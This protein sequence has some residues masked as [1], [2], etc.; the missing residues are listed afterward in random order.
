M[1]DPPAG[2]EVAM[3]SFEAVSKR[4]GSLV[5]IDQVS[6]TL[7]PGHI[8]SIIGPNGAGKSTLINLAA[9]S[10]AVSAGRIM[11]DG[12][13]LTRLKKH[14]ICAAGLSRTYQNIRLFD[15]ISAVENL[16][17][18]LFREDI[19][20]L[21]A[22]VFRPQRA[23]AIRALRRER[24]MAV[25]GEF[26][27]ASHADEPAR[28]LPYGKQKLLEIARA[29]VTEPRVLLLDEPAAGLNRVESDE[30]RRRLLGL[31]RPG[32]VIV[33]IE[34]DMNLVMSLSD[35]IVVLHR[36]Q[37]LFAG[38]PTEVRENREV[39]EAYLGSADEHAFIRSAARNRKSR[40]GLRADRDITR[41]E[42]RGA[43][44]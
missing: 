30:L 36:G 33:I 1:V 39:E 35:R 19:G 18:A 28:N 3:L 44:G 13:D 10:Y 6:L 24:C 21:F 7:K 38:T 32:R 15:G 2:L 14:R 34:H 17:V 29:I 31:K 43:A 5:A 11:L 22:E 37:L 20:K 16:E 27:L 41:H 23:R 40:V 9:G 4:F 26:D 42:R 25:L 12:V 8:H